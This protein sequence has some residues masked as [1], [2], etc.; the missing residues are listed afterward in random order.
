MVLSIRNKYGHAWIIC[1]SVKK[2]NIELRPL[3]PSD[4][5]FLWVML[6]Q[7]FYVQPGKPLFSLDTQRDPDIACYVRSWGRPGDWGL[8][9]WNG[10]MPVGAVWMRQWSGDEKGYGYVSPF[11]PE[12]S[13]A[14]LPEYRNGDLGVRMLKTIIS[15]AKER[16]PG[17]SLSVVGGCPALRM[18]ESLGFHQVGKVLD[19]PVLLQEWETSA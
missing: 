19:F 11:I 2:M 12:L 18:Y 3:L 14:L 1:L 9:A 16:F 8:M 10:Q 13:I 6:H 5:P 17:L 15:M 4:E 7:A